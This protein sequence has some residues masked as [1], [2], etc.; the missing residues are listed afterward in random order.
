MRKLVYYIASSI[1]GFIADETG[2]FDAFPASEAYLH[3]IAA[4]LPETLPT[5]V[6][7]ALGIDRDP[8]RFDTVLM[9]R[10]TYEPAL[11]AQ[12]TSPYAP[13]RQ[14]V[15]SHTLLPSTD[16]AVTVL[17]GDPVPVV[18][19]L[20]AEQTHGGDIWLC[21]GGHLAAQLASE[22]DEL[23]IKLNPVVLGQGVP[24]FRGVAD[25]RRFVLTGQEVQD[26]GVLWLH[27]T[28]VKGDSKSTDG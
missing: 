6:R 16:P 4:H 12:I 20:K 5:H 25:T 11:L 18:Q 1:D 27:Y 13:L 7:A 9:G 21:G 15:F 3:H 17:A 22:I 26:G 28:A 24:L 8:Q 14:Y 19:R 23:L 10:A 2:A